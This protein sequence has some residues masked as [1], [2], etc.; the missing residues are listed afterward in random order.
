MK[1]LGSSLRLANCLNLIIAGLLV[2]GTQQAVAQTGALEELRLAKSEIDTRKFGAAIRRLDQTINAGQMQQSNMARALYLRGRAKHASGRTAE[3]IA[4]LNSAIWFGKLPSRQQKEAIALR[5]KAYQTSG[6]NAPSQTSS[7]LSSTQRTAAGPSATAPILPRIQNRPQTSARPI[8]HKVSQ[9]IHSA[10]GL[11]EGQRTRTTTAPA[12]NR[13]QQTWPAQATAAQRQPKPLPSWSQKVV[14][15]TVRASKPQ[16]QP[17]QSR[18]STATRPTVPQF[19]QKTVV[20]KRASALAA[21]TGTHVKTWSPLTQQFSSQP[22]KITPRP[23]ATTTPVGRTPPPARIAVQSPPAATRVAP[24]P[25]KDHTAKEVATVPA[26]ATK[27]KPTIQSEQ[28]TPTSALSSML[29]GSSPS[30]SDAISA[31][32]RLQAERR[33]RIQAHNKQFEAQ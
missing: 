25:P 33:A 17:I 20:A 27:Q 21:R 8:Q 9:P 4:D 3:A 23:T 13:K 28:P 22:P 30:K 31:A 24:A 32:D 2:L 7:G 12:T 10:G 26:Q 29:F 15:G 5:Q 19:R 14:T 16:S 1:N 6:V 18:E 11:P